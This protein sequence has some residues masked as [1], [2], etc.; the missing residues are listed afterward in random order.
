MKNEAF[1]YT[2][3]PVL[4]LRKAFLK[5]LTQTRRVPQRYTN[6]QRGQEHP[7][8][9][10]VHGYVWAAVSGKDVATETGRARSYKPEVAIE[11]C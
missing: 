9:C 8:V 1:R 3:N 4:R 2:D 10:T 7:G 11:L 5:M 6:Q